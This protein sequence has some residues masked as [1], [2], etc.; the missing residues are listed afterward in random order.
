M[1]AYVTPGHVL[2]FLVCLTVAILYIRYASLQIHLTLFIWIAIA[3]LATEFGPPRIKIPLGVLFTV[4]CLL[5]LRIVNPDEV[6][7][8]VW[9]G[10]LERGPRSVLKPGLH[11]V[12]FFF[13]HI[14]LVRVPTKLFSFLFSEKTG[15]PF[16]VRTLGKEENGKRIAPIKSNVDGVFYFRLAH[17][18]PDAVDLLI[19]SDV[20]FDDEERMKEEVRKGITDDVMFVVGQ[21]YYE[22]IMGGRANDELSEEINKRARR[23]DSPLVMAGMFGTNTNATERGLGEARFAVQFVHL[24]KNLSAQI[25]NVEIA[26]VAID[27]GVAEGQKTGKRIGASVRGIIA[28]QLGKDPKDL[29]D[30]EVKEGL[31]YAQQQTTYEE[32]NEVTFNN[33]VDKVTVDINSAGQPMKEGSALAD[34][35]GGMAALATQWRAAQRPPRGR[36]QGGQGGQNK[37]GGGNPSAGGG[38]R[39]PDQQKVLDAEAHFNKTGKYPKWDPLAREPKED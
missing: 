32:A 8:R 15:N 20:P 7:K 23:A 6:A 33:D 39:T 30:D 14:K 24:P 9:F 37:P 31:A 17:D 19:E 36:G 11:F 16:E 12:P 1:Y 13:G 22:D 21:K 29:T 4:W 34:I 18:D 38:G 27:E 25:D 3:V 26:K 28:A 10:K 35:V 5:S 2:A